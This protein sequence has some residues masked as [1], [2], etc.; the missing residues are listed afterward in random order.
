MRK[1]IIAAF[2][3]FLA[4]SAAAL[5]VTPRFFEDFSLDK[6]LAG[7]LDHVSLA[8]DGALSLAPAYEAL[9]ETG[10]AYIFSMARDSRG[11]IYA[12]TG[13]N[14]KV[15]RVD[16][17]GKG[18]LWFQAKEP[19]VFAL[20][21]D[22]SDVLYAGTSPD[23]RI[24]K[25]T[26][27]DEYE[28]F[29]NPEAKY[30]WAMVFDK[31]G[32]LYAG[33]GG[34]GVIRKID[35]NGKIENPGA[36]F[37]ASGDSHVRS[38]IMR[39]GNLLAGTSPGGKIVEITPEGKGFTLADT[40]LEEINAL[41]LGSGGT[42]YAAAS[43]SSSAA[44]RGIS[45]TIITAAAAAGERMSMKS[46]VYAI[47]GNGDTE[48]L[49]DS[50]NQAVYDIAVRAD[51]KLLLA[52][53]PKGRLLEIDASGNVSFLTDSP[54]EDV[55]RLVVAGDGAY[56]ATSNQGKVYRLRIGP[57]VSGTYE[58]DVL[59][60]GTVASWGRIFWRYSGGAEVEISTRAGNTGT[61]DK[62][63]SDW[64]D[65]VK[66]PGDAISGPK[67][68]Y[69]QWRAVF[70]AGTA[71]DTV[72][73]AAGRLDQVRISCLAQNLRPR[74]TEITALP[75]GVELQAQPSLA[76]GMGIAGAPPGGR[77]LLAPRERG[78]ELMPLDP[79]Q[80]LTQGAQSFTWKAVD[81]NDDALEYSIYFKGEDESGWKPLAKKIKDTFYAV[82]TAALPDGVYRLKVIASDEPSNPPE[83]AL[84]G[85]KISEPF[86]IAGATPEV[87]ITG[88]DIEGK[89]AL[90]RFRAIVKTGSIASAEFSIDG[91]EWRL[92]FPVDGIADSAEEEYR[93]ITPEL[94]PGEHLI[95]IRAGDRNG[96]T[97]TAGIRVRVP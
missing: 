10:E 53:G 62:S 79:K 28:E 75:P 87:K 63:W 38:L 65:S 12:G 40:P 26:G 19:N 20:A 64:S 21:V 3:A 57:A 70:K 2:A 41:A 78:R 55:T 59:D 32:N 43:A 84:A 97:G 92:V 90:A 50:G 52:T 17:Q 16:A 49:F 22:A 91:G 36:A 58:S 51:G 61:P 35:K 83:T 72:R 37:Y 48:V 33:T 85:E 80:V 74:V 31:A 34:E 11:N 24:Y 15:F 44:P 96:T 69:L 39:D 13:G 45:G 54:E 27:E 82:N 81:D 9:F 95:G 86:V 94:S 60:A 76:G 23:G 29:F 73:D 42:V 66:T 5:A 6:L 8:P 67:A 77:P 4:L 71:A 47:G 68:R 14:G 88:S 25:I 93:I 7:S 56:T 46:L 18:T 89:K 30:I 1:I